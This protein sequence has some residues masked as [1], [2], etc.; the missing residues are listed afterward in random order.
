MYK[1]GSLGR[2][3]YVDGKSGAGVC[4]VESE[5]QTVTLLLPLIFRMAHHC[6]SAASP[7]HLAGHLAVRTAAYAYAGGAGRDGLITIPALPAAT[8]ISFFFTA[9]LH[10]AAAGSA[11]AAAFGAA[12]AGRAASSSINVAANVV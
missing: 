4:D 9:C 10:L 1:G 5:L 7:G 3:G 2:G 8:A 11:P 6:S 12:A